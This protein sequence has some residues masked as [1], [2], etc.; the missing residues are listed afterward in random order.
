MQTAGQLGPHLPVPEFGEQ[1]PGRAADTSR[2]GPAAAGPAP[3]DARSRQDIIDHL[4]RHQPGQLAQMTRA[5]SPA[6]TFTTRVNGVASRTWQT[7]HPCRPER[8]R[9]QACRRAPERTSALPGST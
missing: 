8:I 1:D 4:E 7:E 5:N 3:A 6:A 9:W 2:P